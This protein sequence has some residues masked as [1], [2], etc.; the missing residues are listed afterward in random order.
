MRIY[1]FKII[2][3]RID[4]I[5]EAK[6]EAEQAVTAY[7]NEMERGYQEALS[8][9][10]IYLILYIY[11]QYNNKIH[12]IYNNYHIK[13]PFIYLSIYLPDLCK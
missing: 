13:P 1:I 7:R 5:K 2:L 3:A 4:R 9:V 12:Y 10:F 11:L 6:V 8:K